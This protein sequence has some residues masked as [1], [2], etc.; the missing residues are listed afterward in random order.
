MTGQGWRA[1]GAA[2]VLAAASPASAH[3]LLMT[4]NAEGAAVTGRVYYSDGT[5]GADQSIEL[6]DLT[7]PEAQPV[8]LNTDDQ[9]AYRF[10]ATPGHRYAVVAH[11]EEGHTTEM[12]LTVGAGEHGRLVDQPEADEGGLPPAWAVIGGAL[13]LSAVVALGLRLRGRAGAGER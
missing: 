1:A 8:W 11:G 10:A 2:L 6:R 9:G 5:S 3:G 13:L 7:R 12:Q 4:A